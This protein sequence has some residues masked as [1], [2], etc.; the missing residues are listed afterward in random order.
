MLPATIAAG[1]YLPTRVRRELDWDVPIQN[2]AKQMKAK[3]VQ[4]WLAL[5]GFALAIDFGFR[6]GD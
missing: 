4:E 6:P 3:R 2:G 5:A 1:S